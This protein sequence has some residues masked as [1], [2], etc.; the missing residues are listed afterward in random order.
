MYHSVVYACGK[1]TCVAKEKYF[2]M[3]KNLFRVINF[4]VIALVVV[5]K[6]IAFTKFM[7]KVQEIIS[8]TRASCG[9]TRNLIREINYLVTSLVKTLLSRNFCQSKNCTFCVSGFSAIKL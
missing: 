9:K 1:T 6:T 4:L 8:V 3:T 2:L 5:R 7:R